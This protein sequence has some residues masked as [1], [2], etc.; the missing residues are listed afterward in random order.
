MTEG[1]AVIVYDGE[2]V[3]C[4][5]SIAFVAAH[6]AAGRF[7]FTASS[8][9][10]GQALLE[11]CGVD[12]SAPGSVVLVERGKA[13][14]KSEAALR[15]AAQLDP[16]WSWLR[17]LRVVPRFVRDAAYDVVARH[18]YRWF[19]RRDGCGLPSAEVRARLLG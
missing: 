8:L 9:P 10:A 3:L 17:V 14:A 2:C 7:R 16:P 19:G 18:R 4:D 1:A 11:A 15:I 13:F 6:D 5:R 12:P